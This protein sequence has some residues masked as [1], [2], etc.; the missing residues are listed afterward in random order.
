M[1]RKIINELRN[2]GFKPSYKGFRYLKE[3]I[4]F[5]IEENNYY[6]FTL[7]EC[8][9]HLGRVHKV[10]RSAIK[11]DVNYTLG[12]LLSNEYSKSKLI[13]YL[14]LDSTDMS[15]RKILQIIISNLVLN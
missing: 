7:K 13:N 4:L 15:L 5:I 11:G 8:Y 1:E 12:I 6:D 14:D 10:K 3:I 9:A 2:A